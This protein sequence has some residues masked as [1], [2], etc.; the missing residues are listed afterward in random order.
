MQRTSNRVKYPVANSKC[1]TDQYTGDYAVSKHFYT[2]FKV[3]GLKSDLLMVGLHLL[4][5]P[6]RLD[7]CVQREAQATVIQQLV[8]QVN[9]D[10]ANVIILGDLNDFD[11]K[12]LDAADSVPISGV[13]DFLKVQSKVASLDN[14]AQNIQ[15]QDQRYSCWYD[16][17]SNCKQDPHELTMIDHLLL[18]PALRSLAT[19]A[20]YYH[21]YAPSCQTYYSDH[22]PV[23]LKINT[24]QTEEEEQE[25]IQ[26]DGVLGIDVK[27]F[28]A[29]AAPIVG[30]L[31]L[32]AAVGVILFV[33]KR[34]SGQETVPLIRGAADN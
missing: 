7:R 5:F 32:G 19:E 31:L 10:N 13:L 12:V 18:S 17:N 21:G 1:G 11:P 6:D 34:R 15:V 14:L 3:Q 25:P 24:V 4:A 9:A 23:V 33:R 27:T 16:K 26:E 8:A 20:Y 28:S 29:V 30:V 2:T 22:W